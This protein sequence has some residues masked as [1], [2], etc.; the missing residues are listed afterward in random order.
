MS[1]SQTI[2][3][4]LLE[5]KAV[6]LSPS[7]PFT[8]ASG[9][10]SPIYTDNRVT[11]AYPEVRTRIEQAFADVVKAEF[12]RSKSL[13]VQQQQVF[14][15]AQLLPTIFNCLLPISVVNPKIMV[16]EIKSKVVSLK[17]KKWYWLRILSQ[18]EAQY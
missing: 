1:L 13:Q 6:S 3:A 10:Q 14:L 12:P 15:M 16:Q 5:I 4:D 9:I 18:R 11:L 17:G 8:W 2:A 7:A